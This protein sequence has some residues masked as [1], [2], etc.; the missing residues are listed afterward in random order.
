M[1]R[2]SRPVEHSKDAN[3]AIACREE[4]LGQVV[5]VLGP[6]GDVDLLGSVS[7]DEAEMIAFGINAHDAARAGGK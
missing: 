1:R 7:D 5:D 2:L 6:D 4:G 3:V